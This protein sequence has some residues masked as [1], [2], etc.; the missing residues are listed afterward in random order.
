MHSS[1][2][3]HCLCQGLYRSETEKCNTK[4]RKAL[5]HSRACWEGAQHPTVRSDCTLMK[6]Q[7]SCSLQWLI[8]RDPFRRSI[9]FAAFEVLCLLILSS[10]FLAMFCNS[11]ISPNDGICGCLDCDF[12]K[13]ENLLWVDTTLYLQHSRRIQGCRGFCTSSTH[14]CCIFPVAL[15]VGVKEEGIFF[16][17]QHACSYCN[18]SSMNRQEC[19]ELLGTSNLQ[20]CL[21]FLR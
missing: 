7:D 4:V 8:A 14:A 11:S 19:P 12:R 15:A 16:V 6:Q 1:S 9:S 17:Q 21:M 10:T 13:E 5:S 3:V 20:A 2:L 18:S